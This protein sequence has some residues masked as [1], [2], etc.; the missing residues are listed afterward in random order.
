MKESDDSNRE[1]ASQNDYPDEEDEEIQGYNYA[2]ESSSD[3]YGLGSRQKRRKRKL[4]SSSDVDEEE[5]ARRYNRK[6]EKKGLES[7]LDRIQRK[8]KTGAT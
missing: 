7:W 8:M 4:D 2:S 5:A 1:S 3:E 6:N